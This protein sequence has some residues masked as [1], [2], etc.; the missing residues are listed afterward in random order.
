MQTR[1]TFGTHESR[2]S[3][4][5]LPLGGVGELIRIEGQSDALRQ[6]SRQELLH[7]TLKLNQS[8]RF[9]QHVVVLNFGG[10]RST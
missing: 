3:D 10:T 9:N 5:W 2:R 4:P 7:T 8:D 6:R 1:P